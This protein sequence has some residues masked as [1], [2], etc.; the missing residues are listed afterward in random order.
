M[1]KIILT[2]MMAVVSLSS[3]AQF[4]GGQFQKAFGAFDFVKGFPVFHGDSPFSF[5]WLREAAECIFFQ[6]DSINMQL[7]GLIVKREREKL[8]ILTK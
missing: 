5:G 2:L 1:K 7:F 6:C 4:G 8:R 3:F